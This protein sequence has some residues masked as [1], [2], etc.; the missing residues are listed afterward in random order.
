MVIEK[1][2]SA[3]FQD[4]KLLEFFTQDKLKI[5]KSYEKESLK[6]VKPG[7]FEARN[8]CINSIIQFRNS[9]A[10]LRRKNGQNMTQ[11]NQLIGRDRTHP[12]LLSLSTSSSVLLLNWTWCFRSEPGMLWLTAPL[13]IF[14]ALTDAQQVR[15]KFISS[16]Y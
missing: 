1:F 9:E 16:G 4:K 12:S 5:R 14:S 15:F 10:S 13:I 8:F 11:K 6:T 2:T 7:W 3:W